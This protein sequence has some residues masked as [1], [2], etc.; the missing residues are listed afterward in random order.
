MVV[1]RDDA[2]IRAFMRAAVDIRD[3]TA[4]LD[5]SAVA[6]QITDVVLGNRRGGVYDRL[7]AQNIRVERDRV[8]FGDEHREL[9]L[10]FGRKA[11]YEMISEIDYS[12]GG[13]D[14]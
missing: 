3:R 6:E 14:Y 11:V 8:V 10:D 9:G 12:G 13:N 4:D 5:L 1:E 2:F 7:I